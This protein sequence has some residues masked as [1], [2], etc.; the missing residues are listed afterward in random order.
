MW[1]TRASMGE[2]HRG[3]PE[4]GHAIKITQPPYRPVA[5]PIC[6]QHPQDVQDLPATPVSAVNSWP[7]L[8]S[9]RLSPACTL[10]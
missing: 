1:V 3:G 4:M 9:C 2:A 6:Q 8:F 10:A 7:W 5:L